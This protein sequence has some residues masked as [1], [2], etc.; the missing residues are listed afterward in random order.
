MRESMGQAWIVGLILA[1]TL[2][3]TSYLV[4]MINYS[5]AFKIK[6]EL[7]HIIEKYEGLSS[8][9]S[10]SVRIINNYLVNS[11][12]DA[13]G[14][15]ECNNTERCYGAKKILNTNN[16]VQ[17]QNNEKYYYCVEYIS[18]NV[19]EKKGYYNVQ[20][21]LKVDIP[22]LGNFGNFKIKGQTIKI[23]Y[24]NGWDSTN[25]GYK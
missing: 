2:I 11:G 3:F 6:N 5:S 10:G 15:C 16:L 23:K 21:F 13:V 19:S 20:L 14:T 9:E 18:N 25:K 17:A 4:I 8:G 22:V 1:F 12:Y 24:P 7:V